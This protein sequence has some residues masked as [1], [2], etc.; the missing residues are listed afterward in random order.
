MPIPFQYCEIVHYLHAGLS[1]W[2]N[3]HTHLQDLIT[4]APGLEVQATNYHISSSDG[5][6]N[7]SVPPSVCQDGLCTETYPSTSPGCGEFSMAVTAE[8]IA[9]LGSPCNTTNLG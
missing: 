6:I 7:F 1:V 9:G 4:I 5:L 3:T 2:N 8:N